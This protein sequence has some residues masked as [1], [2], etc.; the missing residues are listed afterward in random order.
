MYADVLF[1]SLIVILPIAAIVSLALHKQGRTSTLVGLILSLIA[2]LVGILLS[3]DVI[4]TGTMQLG[5]SLQTY[6]GEWTLFLD[7]LGAFF[8]LMLCIVMV[9]VS[10]YSI[11]YLRDYE[12]KYDPGLMGALFALFFLSLVLVIS[13]SNAILFII[14]WECMSVTSYLLVVYEN[15]KEGVPQ[16]GHLYLIMTHMGTALIMVAFLTMAQYSG[17]YDL[18]SFSGVGAQISSLVASAIF[19]LLFVGFGTKAGIIPLHIWLPQAHPAAPSNIS[20]LMSGVMVKMALLM[21]IRGFFEYLGVMQTWWGL[22][23]LSVGSV[24]ALLGVLYALRENDIKVALAYSTVENIGIILIALGASMV[25]QSYGLT[26][27]AALALLAALFQSLNHAIFKSLL[28]LGAGAVVH[29][30][31]GRNMENM[32]GL[33]KRMPYTSAMMLMALLSLAAIPPFAGFVSEW[34]IFQALLQSATL[35]DILVKI[36]IPISIAVLALTGALACALAVRIFGITFLARPRSDQAEHAHE[37]SLPMLLGMSL[38][39]S[40]CVLFGVLSSWLIPYFDDVT[41]SV[42]GVGVAPSLVDGLVISPGN[43]EFST[44]APLLIAM[45]TVALVALAWLGGTYYGGKQENVKGDTWDCGTPLTAR[46]QYTGTALS[47][48]I[49]RVFSSILR[50]QSEIRTEFTSSPYVKREMSYHLRFTA[51]FERY[52]Y[53]PVCRTI[54]GASKRVTVIQTGSIQAYLAYIFAILVLLLIIFR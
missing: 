32:G 17:S 31:H 38:L 37:S 4:T 6:F 1:Q 19:L 14:V 10:V 36:I 33:A 51:V 11:G 45:F 15:R 9:S 25:F 34:L 52:L 8:L 29:A 27:L 47:N 46:N 16:A 50:P 23:V 28:F 18:S 3:I 48:P 13:A 35:P 40:L 12:G 53:R 24:S 41:A 20:A 7:Q 5:W 49:V 44:M 54:V 22:L 39:A 2:A 42:L 26:S 30:T 43:S 21:M